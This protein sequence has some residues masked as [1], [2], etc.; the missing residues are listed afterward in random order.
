MVLRFFM[1]AVVFFLACTSAERDNFCDERST[2]YYEERSLG[3]RDY[4]F[5]DPRDGEEYEVEEIGRQKGCKE[6]IEITLAYENLRYNASGSVCYDNEET[7]ETYGRLYD[8]ETAMTACPPG[9]RLPSNSELE[10]RIDYEYFF[11][12]GCL[13]TGR[14]FSD[15][16][17]SDLN[18]Y[19]YLW[20]S[21]EKD[22]NNAYYY[23]YAY[24][25]GIDGDS[26][27]I[28]SSGDKNYNLLSVR[29][30]KDQLSE[31]ESTK[32]LGIFK[33]D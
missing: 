14:G 6:I 5:R 17:F 4:R 23:R 29:C 18:T 30:F 7:C 27:H 12:F 26:I 33:Y 2:R 10:K 25:K 8:W 28:I 24:Y 1:L 3:V 20:T 13:L 19:C 11:G 32:K 16:S 21:T 9:W 15:G 22:D 31:S